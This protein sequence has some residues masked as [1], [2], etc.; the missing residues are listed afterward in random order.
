MH[1]AKLMMCEI[2]FYLSQKLYLK[3]FKVLNKFLKGKAMQVI[4]SFW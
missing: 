3:P 1:P 2:P 4:S